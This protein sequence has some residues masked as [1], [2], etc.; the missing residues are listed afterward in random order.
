MAAAIEKNHKIMRDNEVY[1]KEVVNLVL[2]L[3]EIYEDKGE[4]PG[5]KP[6]P[7]KPLDQEEAKKLEVLRNQAREKINETLNKDPKI[8]SNE[9]SKPN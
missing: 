4:K 3:K 6:A 5:E 2:K 9:L 8:S 1:I 7:Q